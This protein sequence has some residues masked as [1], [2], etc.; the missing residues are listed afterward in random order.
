MNYAC[1]LLA[2]NFPQWDTDLFLFLNGLHCPFMD[3]VMWGVSR[4]LALA[5]IYLAIIVYAM[6]RDRRQWRRGLFVV[7]GF[8][9]CILLADRISSGLIKPIFERLRPTHAL[10]DA[11]HVLN[12]YRGGRYGFVSSHAANHF[13]FAMFSLLVLRRRWY[14]IGIIMVACVIGYSRIYLGVHY[15]LDVFCGA[16]LGI[17]IGGGVYGGYRRAVKRVRGA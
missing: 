13:A 17:A 7:L 3:A 5:P 14:S 16:G 11:V 8:V 9:L 1:E 15:P 12:N 2:V 10:G 6:P 4:N